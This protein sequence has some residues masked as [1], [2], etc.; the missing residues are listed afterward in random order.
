MPPPPKRMP[1]SRTPPARGDS[2]RSTEILVAGHRR[3]RDAHSSEAAQDYLEVIAD[4]IEASGEARAV[5][6]ARRLGVTPAT[7]TNTIDRLQ[8]K[9]LVSTRPYRSIFLTEPGKRLAQESRH[10]HR[11]VAD[12]LMALGVRPETAWPDAEGIEHHVSD[13]TLEAFD[14]FTRRNKSRR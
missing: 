4:L 12:F 3:A 11:I 9:G 5:E 6:I 7:V 10:R 14:R 13:E 8:R 1:T 2:V